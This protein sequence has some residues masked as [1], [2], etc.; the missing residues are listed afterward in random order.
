M[1][2]SILPCLTG[3]D[4]LSCTEP[5]PLFCILLS[6]FHY[7]PSSGTC[8]GLMQGLLVLLPSLA[9]IHVA[10]F[11]HDPSFL[12]SLFFFGLTE[13]N[14]CLPK[15]GVT[16]RQLTVCFPDPLTALPL[17][18]WEEKG[19]VERFFLRLLL[20]PEAECECV[21]ASFLTLNQ[22]IPAISNKT[23]TQLKSHQK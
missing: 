5:P 12:E 23:K 4:H 10:G 13:K 17:G 3:D 20:L 11:P 2:N 16:L 9:G 1:R 14:G 19:E 6:A 21:Q 18:I 8:K 7:K 15:K 22:W